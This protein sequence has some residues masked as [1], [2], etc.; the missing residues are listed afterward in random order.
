MTAIPTILPC[1]KAVDVSGWTKQGPR[2]LF[3]FGGLKLMSARGLGA[4]FLEG[5]GDMLPLKILTGMSSK[6]GKNASKY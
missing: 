4:C 3:S 1:M 6:M 2:S 5:F